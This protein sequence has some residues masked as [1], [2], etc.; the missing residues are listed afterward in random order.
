MIS[1]PLDTFLEYPSL[2]TLIIKTL[3]IFRI[4]EQHYCVCLFQLWVTSKSQKPHR[5][6]NGALLECG[7]SLVRARIG[8]NQRL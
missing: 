6:F 1:S 5:W 2:C 3:T 7:R 8:S 4:P